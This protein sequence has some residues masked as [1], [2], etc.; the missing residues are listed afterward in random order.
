MNQLETYLLKWNISCII[1]DLDGTL[2]NTL[3]QHIKAFQ[4]LFKEINQ[5]ISYEAI[6]ENMGRTPKDTLL[7]LIPILESNHEKLKKSAD[8]KERILTDLLNEI[9]VFE[10][11]IEVLKYL[12][13]TKK[14]I[15]LASSTPRY[16]VV[17][18][19]KSAKIVHYFK[20]IVT[21]EDISIGKPNPEVFLKAA[22][23]ANKEPKEC[24]VI[25]DS[26]HDIIAAR[27]ANMKIIVVS[28]GKHNELELQTKSPNL[29]INSLKD[30]MKI[31]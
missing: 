24:L 7:S 14:I 18:I 30:L 12:K 16:N 17:K 15:C 23:K 20:Y 21:G 9:P 3:E 6:S 22:K 13:K 10:G 25:G 1:F 5:E 11:T 29:I 2:V 4:I 19:L 28:T 26:T 31:K 8:R 27:R